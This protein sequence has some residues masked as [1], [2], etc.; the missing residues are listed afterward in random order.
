MAREIAELSKQHIDALF[1]YSQLLE[2][3]F[4]KTKKDKYREIAKR[5]KISEHTIKNWIV[6]YFIKYQEYVSEIIA[7]KDLKK[8][9]LEGLTE[10]QTKYVIAR[11]NG[12]SAEEAKILAGY[13]ENTKVDTI[14]KTK[15]VALTM[16]A[17]REELIEDTKFGARAILNELE[18]IKHRA[19]VGVKVVEYVDEV[20]PDGKLVRKNIKEIKSFATEMAAIR[21]IRQMLGYD[22]E[23][24]K[25]FNPSV[26]YDEETGEKTTAL[27]D[28]DM[29]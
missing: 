2:V 1:L 7:R 28:E 14:E 29:R 11:L 24:E 19:K 15:G 3:R 12:K 9:N 26:S 5:M 4:G 13:S 8:L 22:Y 18:D 6:K 20:N 27:S 21:E 16:V 25:K 17:L 23:T 10:K